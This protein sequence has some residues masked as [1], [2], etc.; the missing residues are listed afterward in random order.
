[1][2]LQILGVPCFSTSMPLRQ[3]I[4]TISTL[5]LAIQQ[6]FFLAAHFSSGAPRVD[7]SIHRIWTNEGEKGKAGSGHYFY[8]M[9]DACYPLVERTLVLC[10][11][12]KIRLSDLPTHPPTYMYMYM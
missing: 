5:L 7:F 11:P 6:R 10:T 4:Q 12:Y 3:L 8:H 1:M 2:D 9:W